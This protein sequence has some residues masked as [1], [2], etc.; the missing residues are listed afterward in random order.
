MSG[1]CKEEESMCL[2]HRGAQNLCIFGVRKA[3]WGSTMRSTLRKGDLLLSSYWLVWY[4]FDPVYHA[5]SFSSFT[6]LE[7]FP[8]LLPKIGSKVHMLCFSKVSK[9]QGKSLGFQKLAV[10]DYEGE[11]LTKLC[12]WKF[13]AEE[14]IIGLCHHRNFSI[15]GT[16]RLL[17][18]L[19]RSPSGSHDVQKLSV[20][21]TQT[22]HGAR[23]S[24]PLSVILYRAIPKQPQKPILV[25]SFLWN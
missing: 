25:L 18:K 9:N 11:A 15:C 6:L 8:D 20:T 22:I 24:N 7:I 10:N 3:Q 2:R 23:L 13:L 5:I 16:E 4:G 17:T 12:A 1:S 14:P 21:S 19:S